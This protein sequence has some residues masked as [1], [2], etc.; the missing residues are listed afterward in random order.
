MLGDEGCAARPLDAFGTNVVAVALSGP[1][2]E[3]AAVFRSVRKEKSMGPVANT[4]LCEENMPL[5][6]SFDLS[7]TPPAGVS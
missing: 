5:R 1:D 3:E 4:R 2:V 7:P 6:P